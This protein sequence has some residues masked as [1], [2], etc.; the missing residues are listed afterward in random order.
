MYK[1]VNSQMISL[2]PHAVFNC[3][4][5]H[6]AVFILSLKGHLM[7]KL[8]IDNQMAFLLLPRCSGMN[9][10]KAAP[11]HDMKECRGV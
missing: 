1:P 7:C 5:C 9:K 11:V 3:V 10:G 2:S 8:S 6:D 4:S